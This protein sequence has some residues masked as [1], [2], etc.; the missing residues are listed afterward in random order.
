MLM[1]DGVRE[2]RSLDLLYSLKETLKDLSQGHGG[3]IFYGPTNIT[4]ANFISICNSTNI[5][6]HITSL[7]YL[8]TS[9]TFNFLEAPLMYK[10]ESELLAKL[11]NVTFLYPGSSGIEKSWSLLPQRVSFV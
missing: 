8:I 10:V 3:R 2:F 9:P 6:F 4:D 11:R 7:K 5:P 1:F